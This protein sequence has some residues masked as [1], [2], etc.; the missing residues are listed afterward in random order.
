MGGITTR[1]T[2][3][4]FVFDLTGYFREKRKWRILSVYEKNG[5]PL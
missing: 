3:K 1:P 4:G 5:K 2:M